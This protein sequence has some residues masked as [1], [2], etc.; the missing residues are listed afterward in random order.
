MLKCFFFFF[1][2]LIRKGRLTSRDLI[3]YYTVIDPDPAAPQETVGEA[4]IELGMA[5]LQFGSP[6]VA[7]SQLSHHTHSN[8]AGG[9]ER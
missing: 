8:V 3:L 6:R 2:F 4:G 5:T 9:A 1:F 7:L